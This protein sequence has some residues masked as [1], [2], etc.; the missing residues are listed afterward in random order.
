MY[1]IPRN[2]VLIG[3]KIIALPTCE[4]T[5]TVLALQAERLEEGTL[6]IAE[7]QTKGRGQAGNT[8]LAEAGANLTFSVLLKPTFLEP[9]RQFYLNIVAGLAVADALTSV[10]GLTVWVKWPNDVLISDKK[11]CG[12]LIENQI[13]G[14]K[15]G[16]AVVGIGLNVNQNEFEWPHA[17][18]LCLC[19]G[20]YFNRAEVLEKVLEK[21]DTR[22]QDLKQG[23]WTALSH[24]Y[25]AALY[26]RGSEHAF[27]ANGEM[28]MGTIEGVDDI[29][30]L[31]IRTH[32]GWR[33]F[34]F[35]EVSFLN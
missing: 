3:K 27:E 14:A 16:Q 33:V 8:W 21:L 35:K 6:V 22:Y 15:L 19:A 29:G 12:I 20:R 5:N 32:K 25:H 28:F 30:R 7:S 18:S 34:N 31:R 1:K 9:S 10:S 11:V 13:Q 17:S 23:N 2:T 24:D 26:R 4:S